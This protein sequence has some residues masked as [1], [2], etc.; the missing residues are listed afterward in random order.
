MFIVGS[1]V[2]FLASIAT[3]GSI[4]VTSV[5]RIAIGVVLRFA[6]IGSIVG[7]IIG[8]SVGSLL[9]IVKISLHRLCLLFC[10]YSAVWDGIR[11]DT[12]VCERATARWLD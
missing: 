3:V 11:I 7:G 2:L 5:A 1:I 9:R 10:F 8:L 12:G 6:S 4:A